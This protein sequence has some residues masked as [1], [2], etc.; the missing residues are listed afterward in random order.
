MLALPVTGLGIVLVFADRY[1]NRLAQ[2]AG[3]RPLARSPVG[4]QQLPLALDGFTG[5]DDELARLDAIARTS[6]L[7]AEQAVPVAVLSGTAGVGKTALAVHFAHR[8]AGLFPDGQ[9]YINL[10]GFDPGGSAMEPDEALRGFLD[11]LDVPPERIP[12]GLDAQ[13]A[14]YRSI[15]AGRRV[16]VLLDNARNV[17]QVRPLLPGTPGCLVIVTSRSQLTGLTAAGAHLLTVD[18]LTVAEAR[19][20]LTRRFGVERAAAEPEAVNALVNLCARLPLALAIVA[21]RASAYPHFSLRVMARE[22]TDIQDRLDVLTGGDPMTDLRTVFFWSCRTLSPEAARLFR[23]LGL[24][25]GPEISTL[26]AASLAGA[27]PT[28]VRASLTELTRAHLVVEHRPSRYTF[29]DLLRSYAREQA[30]NTDAPNDRDDAVGR[31]LDHYLHAAH[32]AARLLNP[33]RSPI[34]LAAPRVGVAL[35]S[36]DSRRGALDWFTTEH[37]VL[38]AV[39]DHAGRAG[40]D[41]YAWQLAWTLWTYLEWQGHWNDLAA[42]QSIAL[43]AADRLADGPTRAWAHRLLGRAHTHLDHFDEACR[44]LEQALA[45]YLVAQDATGQAHTLVY[46]AQLHSRQDRDILAIEHASRALALFRADQHLSGQADALSAIGWFHARLGDHDSA[47]NACWEALRLFQ[48]LQNQNFEAYI[49]DGLGYVYHQLGDHQQALS[50]YRQA[51]EL[52]REL[53]DRHREAMALARLGDTHHATGDT[54]AARGA[55]NAALPTLT[56]LDRPQADRLRKLIQPH[57]SN[58]AMNVT[59][60]GNNPGRPLVQPPHSSGR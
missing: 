33:L 8:T 40:L 42:A 28:A 55:W 50:C 1:E 31:A 34:K 57:Y 37:H 15:L 56:H 46:L 13:A 7:T 14:F 17:D 10:R 36:P 18:L 39:V 44:H 51:L 25:P 19:R 38:L 60:T 21:A 52:F 27:S 54:A 6:G 26:A 35:E 9:L 41:T 23:S 59:S 58:E 24:H 5:R 16:L 11:A 49:W 43:Q 4:P 48:R 45:L 32:A 20:L 2:R 30:L 47:L 12:I 3:G 29:H 53:G 22:L